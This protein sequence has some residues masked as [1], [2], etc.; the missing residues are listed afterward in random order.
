MEGQMA[1]DLVCHIK[2]TEIN[3][4]PFKGYMYIRDIVL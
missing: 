3:G 2:C 4:G 1:K